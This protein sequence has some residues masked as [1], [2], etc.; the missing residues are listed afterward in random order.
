[1]R[2]GV[3]RL[4]LQRTVRTLRPMG[5]LLSKSDFRA[6]S[7]CETK[8]FYRKRAYASTADSNEYLEL[9]QDGGYMIDPGF[10]VVTVSVAD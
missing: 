9:L 3:R 4:Q 7:S 8:L 2:P 6:A 10:D 1:M 5:P